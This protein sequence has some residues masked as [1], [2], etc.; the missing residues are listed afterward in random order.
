MLRQF[1]GICRQVNK[2]HIGKC[3]KWLHLR[4]YQER[5]ERASSKSELLEKRTNNEGIYLHSLLFCNGNNS[6]RN[7]KRRHSVGVQYLQFFYTLFLYS[8]QEDYANIGI[9]EETSKSKFE[10]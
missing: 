6:S 9:T 3:N 8:L 1:L 7:K 5:I 4:D 2:K 10:L